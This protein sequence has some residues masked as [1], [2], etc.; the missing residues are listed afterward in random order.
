MAVDWVGTITKVFGAIGQYLLKN[1]L[2]QVDPMGGEH[3]VY[4]YERGD[5]PHVDVSFSLRVHNRNSS[6][7]TLYPERLAVKLENGEADDFPLPDVYL[8]GDLPSSLEPGRRI[9]IG[10]SS[11]LEVAFYSRK[12]YPTLPLPNCYLSGRPLEA[13]IRIAETFGNHREI[14]VRLASKGVTKQ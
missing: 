12:Y 1:W 8:H 5:S 4:T 7:T 14:R 10:G 3:V 13:A 11:T 2:F 6:P 9:E